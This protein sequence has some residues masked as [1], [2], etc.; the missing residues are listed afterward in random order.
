MMFTHFL[1]LE[2]DWLPPAQLQDAI[3]SELSR[4]GEPLRWAVVEANR[5]ETIQVEAVVTTTSRNLMPV[6]T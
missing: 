3:L 5:G 2:L 1:T 6:I 4:Y